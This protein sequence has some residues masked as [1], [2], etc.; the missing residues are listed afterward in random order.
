V[1]IVL[2]PRARLLDGGR[3][4]VGGDPWRVLRLTEG[5]AAVVRELLGDGSGDPGAHCDGGSGGGARAGGGAG[6]SAG[7]ARAGDGAGGS[8]GGARGPGGAETGADGR[9][10]Q[11]L[12]QR[13]IDSGLAHPRVTPVPC[14]EVTV[15]IPVRDR[16][17]QLDRCLGALLAADAPGRV[18]VVDDGSRDAAAVDAVCERTGCEVIRR[19][20]SGGPAAARN[21]ALETV[22]S[23]VVALLDSDCVPEPGWLSLL[24]GVLAEDRGLGA[25]GPRVRPLSARCGEGLRR[26]GSQTFPA[27]PRS[28]LARFTAVRSPLDLGPCPSLVR[29][30]GRTAYL[31]TAALVARREALAPRFDPAL[32]YGEDVDLVWR[33]I[34][35]GWSVRYEPAAVVWH[36]DPERLRPWLAR[37]FRY[38]SSAGPLALRHPERLAP[39][40]IHPRS[41]A[42]LGG[43]AVAMSSRRLPTVAACLPIALHI[44]AVSRSLSRHGVPRRAGA[45]LAL[46]GIRESGAGL[47]RA[48]TMLGPVPLAAALVHPRTRTA[49]RALARPGARRA[50]LALALASPTR[51]YRRLRPRL[52]PLRFAALSVADD[53]AYGAGV[54]AGSL[55]SRTVRAL[56]P[57][58]VGGVSPEA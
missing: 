24:C 55:Q 8:A 10:A 58:I 17:A 9:P 1:N 7:G 45:S 19:E 15:V 22:E 31:P 43:T 50:V 35:R 11:A 5:G 12:A 48:A 16:A 36:D 23:G 37:R 26:S 6:G 33:M 51:D 46:Q 42:V 44:L 54:W 13:L 47:G 30:G 14:G 56:W 4:L 2:D 40:A 3:T 38:G 53:V 57:R 52:D 20:R 32:R 28:A 18:I 27:S 49:A 21:T 41:A 25:V 29:P 39:V 34:D